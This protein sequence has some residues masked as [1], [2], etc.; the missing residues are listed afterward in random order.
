M[1]TLHQQEGI[2]LV[3]RGGRSDAPDPSSETR[4]RDMC[5]TAGRC[6]SRCEPE[7]QQ[8][9]HCIDVRFTERVRAMH[10]VVGEDRSRCESCE[11]EQ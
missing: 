1:L 9:L 11:Q 10:G 2:R 4:P 3:V 7:N 8:G 5:S 6:R